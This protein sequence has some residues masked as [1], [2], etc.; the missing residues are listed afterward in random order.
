MVQ[1][2]E[3]ATRL[4]HDQ[5]EFTR[6]YQNLGIQSPEWKD[7][8]ELVQKA[9]EIGIPDRIRVENELYGLFVYA[10]PLLERVFYNLI[11]NALRHGGPR[12]TSI[13]FWWQYDDDVVCILCEDDGQGIRDDL[14]ERIFERGYGSNTGLGLF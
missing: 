1:L 11:D 6:V 5:I 10:D 3:T 8:G 7:A 4:I 9:T 2:I 13:R 12:L 14:K